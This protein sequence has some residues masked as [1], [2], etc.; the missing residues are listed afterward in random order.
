MAA[1][2]HQR[3]LE[4]AARF[5]E[6]PF[7]RALPDPARHWLPE[8]L[9]LTY[10]EGAA[11]VAGLAARYREAGIGLHHRVALLIENHPHFFLHKLALA[12]VGAAV[13]P[14]NPDWRQAE[15]GWVLQLTTPQLL[16]TLPAHRAGLAATLAATPR[17]PPVV[18]LEQVEAG[19][20]GAREGA[21]AGSIDAG[22]ETLVLFTSGTTGRSKGC[23]YTHEY[24]LALGDWY[25]SLG[26]LATFTEGAETL[27]NPLPVY[28]SDCSVRAFHEMMPRGGCLVTSDRFRA[29]RFWE[30]VRACGA[31]VLH[32]LGVVTSMLM[33]Q[34][35]SPLDRQHRVRLAIGG[36]VEPTLHR[37]FE[38][39][40]GF[41]L[42]E[43]WGM[44]ECM[45]VL[46]DCHPPRSVGQRAVGRPRPGL[47]VR[48]VDDEDRTVPPGTQGELC[49]RHSAEAPRRGLFGGYL[50]D[51]AATEEAWR[52]GWFHTGDFV[53]Q[54]QTGLVFF[55]DRTKHI[56]RRSGE[57]IAAAEVDAVLLTHPAV[58]QCAVV[59]VPDELR[60]EEVMACVIARPTSA[61]GPALAESLVAH[62]HQHLAWFK[63]P[64]WVLFV[65]DL[66]RTGSQKIQKFAV[67]PPGVDGRRQP[68]A[69]DL[70]D[71]KRR[72]Q[73]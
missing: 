59:P 12:S 72:D 42:L 60:G 35:A 52:G 1:T 67:F 64:G 32:Y 3:F 70:R 43:V 29:G 53:R 63:A 21:D 51:P 50:D 65:D 8:G 15:L 54:D 61:P 5:P 71:R 62:V 73:R 24:E 69:I 38:E 9:A 68:G 28:H 16:I 39:R 27:Y 18:L 47:D 45:R 55:I 37:A 11:Q 22:T 10:A 48:V 33:A 56:I 19:L 7:L 46:I 44:T 58:A 23:R 14:L 2:L 31:T 25:R 17:P 66:P 6:R 26:G 49:I 34:P 4:V 20:P 30:D 40:F 57:N 13:V 36:G 41:P